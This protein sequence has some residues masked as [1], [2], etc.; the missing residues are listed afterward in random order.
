M[1]GGGGKNNSG[2]PD[3]QALGAG[4][5]L[6]GLVASGLGIALMLDD[7][8]DLG[9]FSTPKHPS[10]LHHWQIGLILF[11]AGITTLG[12]GVALLVGGK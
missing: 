3:R 10:P 12:A 11:V 4:L 6:G 7:V 9:L 2:L 1:A 8:K 5:T